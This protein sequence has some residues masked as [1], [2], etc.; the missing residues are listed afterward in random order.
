MSETLNVA[1][2]LVEVRTGKGLLP[3]Y[4]TGKAPIATVD[5]VRDEA[6]R[7]LE[8]AWGEDGKTKRENEGTAAED[9][10]RLAEGW[11]C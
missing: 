4:R 6:R 5:A 2:E 8:N 10:V 1:Y 9:V 3:L 11:A 7:V